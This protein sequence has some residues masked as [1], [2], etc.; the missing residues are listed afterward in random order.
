MR[1]FLPDQRYGTS[2]RR[3]ASSALSIS[4]FARRRRR[5]FGSFF[6]SL[7]CFQPPARLSLPEAVRF[8]R[9]AAPRF[10]FIFGIASGL[11]G[12]RLGAQDDVE[13]A[14]LHPGAVVGG[15]HV[16]PPLPPP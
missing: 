2:T 15:P 12:V 9:F 4:V 10:V 3:R 13:H 7:C 11:L 1:P 8:R 5:R 14:P 6:S 16:L